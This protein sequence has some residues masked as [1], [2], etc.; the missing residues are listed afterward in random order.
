M[1]A[2][3]RP[4]DYE[5]VIGLEI[6]VQLKTCSK[7][8]CGCRVEFGAL[9]NT[10]VCPVCLGLPGALPVVNERA[11]ELAVFAALALN[12]EVRQRSVFARKNYFYPDLPKGY[13]I[14]QYDRPLAVGGWL[15]MPQEEVQGGGRIH[16]RR[17]HVE[18][19]S[20]KSLHD[21]F[22]G[23]TAIDLNRAGIPL[24]EIVTEPDLTSPAQARA[25]LGRL[26]R[27]LEY[28][29]VS[30]CNMEEGSLRVDANVSVRPTGSDELATKTEVK[31]MN[32]FSQ[33]E[34]A[35]E[36]EAARQVSDLVSGRSIEHQTML[37]DA[38]R[39]ETRPMRGKEEVH[40]YRYFAEPDIP[41]LDL[42]AKASSWVAER[43]PEL[44]WEKMQRFAVQYGLRAYDAE[45]LT[46]TR[47]L[48]DYFEAVAQHVSDP[49]LVSNW[50]MVEVLA[51][52]NELGVS[53]AGLGLEAERLAELLG[54]V[55]AGTLSHGLGKQVLRGMIRSGRSAEEVMEEEGLQKVSDSAQ[56]EEWVTGALAENPRE[57]ERY[58]G[59][60]EKLLAFF[61]GQVMRKSHGKADPERLRDVLNEAL[62]PHD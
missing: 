29:E 54:L 17:L 45:V 31:N 2:S 33:L 48:A 57:V 40:D 30:D 44:P 9:P 23:E 27:T 3:R 35:L 5:S 7:M 41:T 13:Q 25:F 60:E 61:V 58:R 24:A 22:P 4:S 51:V 15:Q 56:L 52:A 62:G 21:R 18:E 1:S 32:S 50:V 42:G 38:V 10:H 59:G 28:L 11:I 46:S 37:W 36:Y 14:T 12:C 16:I 53:V 43:L 49:K 6:H 8:F 26:K 34:R 47:E 20:G 39:N 55:S 19:D